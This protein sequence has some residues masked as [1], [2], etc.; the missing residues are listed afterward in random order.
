MRAD[1]ALVL[2][3]LSGLG[4]AL[5]H[6]WPKVLGLYLGT[7]RFPEGVAALGF[8]SPVAFAWM[9]ALSELLGGLGVALGLLTRYSAI[10]AALPLLVAAFLRHHAHDHLL[11]WLRLRSASAETL[12]GWGSPELA[13]VYLLPIVAVGL[14]GPGR[15][16][17]DGMRGGARGGKKR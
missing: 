14:L 5:F 16:S 15:L 4:L 12:A 2:L 8:P 1:L 17:V 6:G 10:A 3:R 9:A 11:V 13:L 7:S